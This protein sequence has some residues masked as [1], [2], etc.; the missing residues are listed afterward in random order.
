MRSQTLR[1]Q[2]VCVDGDA[3]FKVWLRL[4]LAL[5]IASCEDG[6]Q[7]PGRQWTLNGDGGKA[8]LTQCPYL[9]GLV[10]FPEGKVEELWKRFLVCGQI[11]V[12]SAVQCNSA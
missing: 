1:V 9:V 12:C 8:L 5:N 11:R 10:D 2:S 3:V 6:V 4:P 7:L